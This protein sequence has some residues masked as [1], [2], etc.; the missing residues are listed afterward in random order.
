MKKISELIKKYKRQKRLKFIVETV[1]KK[2]PSVLNNDD[3][4]LQSLFYV[5]LKGY[6]GNALIEI[7][8][9]KD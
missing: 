6:S 4:I 8:E 2:E 7:K 3:S 1:L 5:Y 9:E